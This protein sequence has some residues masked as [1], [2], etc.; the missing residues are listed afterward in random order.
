MG[1]FVRFRLRL[2]SGSA[3]LILRQRIE[4][5]RACISRNAHGTQLPSITLADLS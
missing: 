1:G 3:T 4:Q 5:G 2:R